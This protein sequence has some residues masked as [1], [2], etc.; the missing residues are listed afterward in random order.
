MKEKVQELKS[1]KGEAGFTLVELLIVLAILAILVAV[2]LPNFTGLI[3]KGQDTAKAA[4]KNILQTAVDA[5]MA[6][7]GTATFTAVSTATCDTAAM[8]LY[9]DYMRSANTAYKYTITADGTVSDPG[10]ACDAG[11]G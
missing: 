6:A 9:P 2:V 4:E 1:R 5:K 10:D 3:G 11:G 7:E 8:G